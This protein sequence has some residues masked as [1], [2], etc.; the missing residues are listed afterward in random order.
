MHLLTV[1]GARPQ[2]IKLAPFSAEARRRGHRETILHTGQHYDEGMSARFFDELGI[3]EP[4]VNLQVGSGSHGAMTARA[5]E[6]IEAEIAR[7]KPDVVVVFGDTNSTLAGALAAAKLGVRSAHVEA[8]LRSFDRS[9]P[10]EINRIVADHCCDL[11]LAPNE[12]ARRNLEGEGLGAKAV[13]TG[14]I[15]VDALFA[16]RD[17]A[18]PAGEVLAGLGVAPGPFCLLTVHRAANTDDPSRLAGILAG[19][20]GAGTAV[21]PVHPRTRA[22]MAATGVSLPANVQ[23]VE[24]LGYLDTVSLA[25]EATAVVT[26]SGGLQK[27]AYLLETP[28]VTLRDNTEWTE[29]LELGW[30][31]LVGASTGAIRAAIARPPRG[32]T[33]PPVYGDGHAAERILAAIEGLA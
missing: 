27:E 32:E 29:T 18:R 10:E 4:D 7:R 14:D 16:A 17:R 26:D 15:M 19:L 22:A 11:L 33:H 9:M 13:V 12:A 20:S 3:P 31:V 24:P 6:G 2:F 8:G 25:R 23:A 21:F 30:N 5:L 28:C 1:V